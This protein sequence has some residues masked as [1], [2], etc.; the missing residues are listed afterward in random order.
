MGRN[1][2]TECDRRAQAPLRLGRDLERRWLGLPDLV[3]HGATVALVEAAGETTHLQQ[4]KADPK[5]DLSIRLGFCTPTFAQFNGLDSRRQLSW[6]EQ[7]R[8][9]DRVFSFVARPSR[10]NGTGSVVMLQTAL[11]RFPLALGVLDPAL[12]PPAG[13]TVE[14]TP[15]GGHRHPPDAAR[16]RVNL[17]NEVVQDRL[18]S[19]RSD[20]R[21]RVLI[22]VRNKR[23]GHDHSGT[24]EKQDQGEAKGAGHGFC[25]CGRRK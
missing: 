4:G 19:R 25:F 21:W 16:L 2:G 5:L 23:S 6:L 7:S 15:A 14:L 12:G 24:H 10:P 18:W 17:K 8:W 3:Q 1:V 11:P 20:Q 22:G 13:Q 9:C